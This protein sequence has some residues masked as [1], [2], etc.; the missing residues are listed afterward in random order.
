MLLRERAVSHGLKKC[1]GKNSAVTLTTYL[2]ESEI[3]EN[4]AMQS[5][6][7]KGKK[8]YNP[9]TFPLLTMGVRGAEEDRRLCSIGYGRTNSQMFFIEKHEDHPPSA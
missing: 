1:A 9:L 3:S 8:C 7:Q 5:A 6:T 4:A 2:G